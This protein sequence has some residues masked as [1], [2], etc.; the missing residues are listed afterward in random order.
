MNCIKIHLKDC[1]PFLGKA[2]RDPVLTAYLPYDSDPIKCQNVARPS[3]LLCPGGGYSSVAKRE[4]EPIA[5]KFLPEGYNVF[6]LTYSVAPHAFPTQLREVAAAMELIYENA[7]SWHCDTDRIAIMGFSAG[8][9]LAAHYTNAYD[10]PEVREVFPESKAVN[11]SILCYAVSSADPRYYH[12]GSF[13]NLVGHP[14]PLTQ[15]E[16][17]KFSTNLLV[18]EKTPPTFLWHCVS[19]ASVPVVNSILYARAMAKYDRPF[20]LHIYHLGGHGMATADEQSYRSLT[21]SP[22]TIRDCRAVQEWMPTLFHWLR[23]IFWNDETRM[24]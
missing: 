13:A 17:A 14:E 7:H 19:D 12:K 4:S 22:E 2:G 8:G 6:Q 20:A 9:H 5:L 21:P 15:E 16:I 3:I 23:D 24:R 1:F 10:C 11:A 18:S